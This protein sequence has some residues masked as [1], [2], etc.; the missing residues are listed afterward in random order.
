MGEDFIKEDSLG[1][2]FSLLLC[3]K[4]GYLVPQQIIQNKTEMVGNC[5]IHLITL[6]LQ[7]SFGHWHI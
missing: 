6:V 1:S 4:P 3:F 5:A 2:D 7:H